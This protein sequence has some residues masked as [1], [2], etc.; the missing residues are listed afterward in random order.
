MSDFDPNRTNP[1]RMDP[2]PNPNRLDSNLQDARYGSARGF[3]WNWIIGG[4]AA[5][6][7][8]LVV[9]SFI[10]RSGDQVADTP[11]AVTTGQGTTTPPASTTGP[12]S[13]TGQGTT[14]TPPATPRP[15]T[16]NQ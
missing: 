14:T 9:L 8:L 1:N 12:A 11:P 3:N 15:T 13:S 10:D 5:I 6:V 2:D 16:P 4:I 7:V